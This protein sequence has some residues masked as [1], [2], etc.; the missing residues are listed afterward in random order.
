MTMQIGI[1]A[2]GGIVLAS[3][4][5]S[6][7]TE[8]YMTSDPDSIPMDILSYSKV[9][10]CKKHDIAIAISGM[11]EIGTD[12][13]REL[14]A[15][16]STFPLIAEDEMDTLLTAWGDEYFLKTFPMP[17]RVFLVWFFS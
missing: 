7:T 14:V 2:D 4:T 13:A 11:G 6:R 3:D 5:K 10:F 17:I 12:P 16:L 15:H 9:A 1:V 8:R